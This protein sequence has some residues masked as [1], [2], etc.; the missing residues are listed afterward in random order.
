MGFVRESAEWAAQTILLVW[1]TSMVAMP[2]V[3]P[4]GSM[5][6]T[7]MTG[8]HVIVDKLAYAPHGSAMSKLL[9][10]EDVRRGDIVVFR[11]PVD[12]RQNYVKRVIGAPGDRIHIANGT[13]YR[14]G[15]KL[16][17]PWAQYIDAV[18]NHYRD[19][20]PS[21]PDSSI[22]PRGV[23]MLRD[24]VHAGELVVPEDN[25]FVMG[26]NRNNSEDSRYWGLVPRENIIGKPVL[27]FWSYDAPT[28][29]LL[30]YSAHHFVDLAQHFFT[31]TRWDRTL[32][33]VH[34]G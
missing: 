15:E 31:K 19:N 22:L 30:E 1:A 9:P 29:D 32:R 3:I 8:D 7:L 26:D 4:S 5:E 34:G 13:V 23:A 18:D 10:Y 24:Y 28:D 20:F 17:E 6:S 14:D 27:V 33:L 25:Y 2:C 11:Y 12:I 21:Q 16:R